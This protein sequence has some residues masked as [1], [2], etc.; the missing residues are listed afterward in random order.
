LRWEQSLIFNDGKL[1]AV[2]D[3]MHVTTSRL[4]KRDVAEFFCPRS[5]SKL[6]VLEVGVFRGH[7][8]AVLASIFGRV[9][10]VDIDGGYLRASAAHT[11]EP[12]NVAF[13]AVDTYADDWHVLRHN[14]IDVVIID[15]DHKYEKVWNDA[16]NALVQLHQV[17]FL[18]FDDFGV[19][20]PVRRVV[21][22]LQALSMLEQCK[23]VGHGKDGR[24]WLL[25]DWGRVNHSEGLLC[26]RGPV[27][28][29]NYS[30]EF[31]DVMFLVFS[32][33]PDP[34]MRAQG[35]IRFKA[36]NGVFAP[37]FGTG[38]WARSY[39]RKG[40]GHKLDTLTLDLPSLV[41]GLWEVQFNR[42]RSAFIMSP[43][44]SA[45]VKWFGIRADRVNQV[46]KTANNQFD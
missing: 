41:P 22:E 2:Q 9:L 8:T 16:Y 38:S 15:A 42:P 6:T 21:S 4:F 27:R 1:Y 33:P 23:P 39:G 20:E 18:V 17:E 3:E 10:A 28:H 14:R 11:G 34:L 35:I 32:R 29:A 43:Q 40:S 12:G 37:A 36:D 30:L 46:F 13:L 45:E 31:V 19:E 25:K 44:G 26:K 7:M 5:P 24:P